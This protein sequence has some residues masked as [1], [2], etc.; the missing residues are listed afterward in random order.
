VALIAEPP[1]VVGLAQTVG[2]TTSLPVASGKAFCNAARVRSTSC[3][4]L[5]NVIF[6]ASAFSRRSSVSPKAPLSAPMAIRAAG[7]RCIDGASGGVLALRA[8]APPRAIAFS[9]SW[10][11]L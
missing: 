5:R 6:R 1:G 11:V 10:T 4:R 7:E 3:P 8:L 2:D 9:E